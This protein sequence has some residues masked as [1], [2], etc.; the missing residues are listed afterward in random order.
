[1][2]GGD[3]PPSIEQE[4]SDL[5][6]KAETK[7]DS[8]VAVDETAAV[9]A[10]MTG[11]DINDF[12]DISTQLEPILKHMWEE[13]VE[14]NE[15]SLASQ[16]YRMVTPQY[17]SALQKGAKTSFLLEKITKK[18]LLYVD[19]SSKIDNVALLS[20]RTKIVD[21]NDDSKDE[22]LADIREKELN[23]KDDE[24]GDEKLPV[25]AQVE[26]LYDVKQTFLSNAE[27]PMT[28]EL[29]KAKEMQESEEE[30]TKTTVL[31]GVFEGWLDGDPTGQQEL[32]WVLAANRPAWEF[33]FMSAYQL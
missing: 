4:K 20:C 3:S 16:L 9:V 21:V 17:F 11:V 30:I 18:E 14:K 8:K 27:A 6:S 25:A 32:R 31:V 24:A 26:V 22:D 15:D 1:M 28:G 33:P 13:D 19:G 23:V 29:G 12:K 7:D 10:A 2:K 5:D